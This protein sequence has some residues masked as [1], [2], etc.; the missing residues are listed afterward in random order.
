[1]KLVPTRTLVLESFSKNKCTQNLCCVFMGPPE[2][3]A[4]A[5]LFGERRS[6]GMSERRLCPGNKKAVANDI[7]SATTWRAGRARTRYRTVPRTVLPKTRV[8]RTWF[9]DARV[10]VP[11]GFEQKIKA[12]RKKR[13]AFI[14]RAGRDSN[15]RPTGS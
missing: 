5:K 3:F 11:S 15:P 1:M 4:H 14:W 7:K 9:L 13:F 12:N 8:L 2:R 10:R 6:D